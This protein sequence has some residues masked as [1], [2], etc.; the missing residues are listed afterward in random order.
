M[1]KFLNNKTTN[2]LKK[3]SKTNNNKHIQK[4]KKTRDT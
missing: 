2:R 1:K 4:T 3:E